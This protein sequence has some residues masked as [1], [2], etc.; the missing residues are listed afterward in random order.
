LSPEISISPETPTDTPAPAGGR[1][2]VGLLA[3]ILS[4]RHDHGARIFNT[5]LAAA[6]IALLLPW[7]TTGTIILIGLWLVAVS[8]TLDVKL[9]ADSFKRPFNF[10]P[11]AL[12][13]IAIVGTLWSE[14]NWGARLYAVSP[15]GKFLVL[16]FAFP[17][18]R[19]WH[20]FSALILFGISI[21]MVQGFSITRSPEP[22][23]VVRDGLGAALGLALAVAWQFARELRKKPA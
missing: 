13:A 1:P 5:D 9:L 8:F 10:W 6:G 2:N 16:P 7:S 4:A 14:A 23:D 17:A 18:A 21:E 22:S 12:V 3:F 19:W 15:V 20:V 11:L